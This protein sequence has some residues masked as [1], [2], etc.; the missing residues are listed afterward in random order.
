MRH[1]RSTR[2]STCALQSSMI[3]SS[4]QPQP[5]PLSSTDEVEQLFNTPTPSLMP[6]LPPM[7][8]NG[9]DMPP[10]L[11][12]ASPQP[13]VPMDLQLQQAMTAL[14]QA[15]TAQFQLGNAQAQAP[16]PHRHATVAIAA[17]R[18]CIKTHVPDPYDGS[19]PSKHPSSLSANSSLEAALTTTK[20]I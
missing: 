1:S 7:S 11:P 10:H 2:S 16:L 19:D 15:M 5:S 13:T 18:S 8:D 3:A 12:D 6:S 9:H 20:M 14:I 17:P 4:S